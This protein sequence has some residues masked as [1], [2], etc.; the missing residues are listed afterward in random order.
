MST[1]RR[2]LNSSPHL[3]HS[4][5]RSDIDGLRAIAI[6]SVVMFHTF[7]NKMPGG[8]IGVDVFFVIS[9]FLIST[10]IFSSLEHDRFSLIEFY[11]RRIRRIFPALILVLMSCLALGWFVLFAD[12]YQQLGKYAAASAGFM[13]NFALW[14]RRS[15]YFDN[16]AETNPLLHLWTL[17]VE[18]QFYIF[19]PLALAFVWRRRINFLTIT[20]AIA[21]I[22]FAL[23]VYL[24]HHNQKAAFYL[25]VPRLWELM[26]GGIL[27]YAML[28]R[29]PLIDRHKNAQSILGFILIF[30]GLLLLNKWKDFPGWWAL[31]PTLG[32]FFIISAGPTAYLNQKILAHR[33]MVWVGLISYPL[34]LWHW[35]I[36]AYLSVIDGNDS[37]QAT[38]G[39]VVFAILLAWITYKFIE[40]PFRFGSYASIK[41]LAAFTLLF[42]IGVF[43]CSC[44]FQYGFPNR[45]LNKT[46]EF[47]TSINLIAGSS[48]SDGSC[49]QFNSDSEVSEEVCHSNSP[50]PEVLFVG[51]SHAMALYS[52]IFSKEFALRSILVSGSACPVY[53]NL[54]YTPTFAQTFANN[55]TQI[56]QRAISIARKYKSVRTVVMANT[57]AYVGTAKPTYRLNGFDLSP[58]DAFLLGNSAFIKEMLSLGKK[59]VFVEDVPALRFSPAQC[60]RRVSFV[61]PNKCETSKIENEN[62]R[63]LYNQYLNKLKSQF[64]AMR[65]FRTENIFCDG[66]VCNSRIAGNWLYH[67]QGHITV[68]AS[69]ILLTKMMND[70]CF[71]S[72][73]EAQYLTNG[74]R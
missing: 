31:L 33:A 30:A 21:V 23:S 59:V 56:A 38:L 54:S 50:N 52:A 60:V 58:G 41:A 9:G 24:S 64:P 39:A 22:S 53:P 69:N 6:L 63:L 71:G 5:Y 51:D 72:D 34:Y 62:E 14:Y 27:A 46:L 13:Q 74:S 47:C 57:F 4:K 48:L 18:E 7:P 17:A 45:S 44:Y 26:V 1:L 65:I 40:K 36:L 11:V 49:K 8:F 25:P 68:Y 29:H 73:G 3:I 67:D 61:D 2:G 32:A 35:P 70:G 16:G 43:G 55:C 10:A 19:W 42:A 12:E 37:V 20:S 66:D 15:G 28:H